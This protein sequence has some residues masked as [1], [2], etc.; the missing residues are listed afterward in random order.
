MLLNRKLTVFALSF[1]LTTLFCVNFPENRF[2]VIVIATICCILLGA[3]SFLK[4]PD[5]FKRIA[6]PSKALFT[7]ALGALVSVVYILIFTGIRLPNVEKLPDDEVYLEGNITEIRYNEIYNTA[8]AKI[9]ITTDDVVKRGTVVSVYFD[10]KSF[11]VSDEMLGEQPKQYDKITFRAFLDADVSLQSLADGV[12]LY[13]QISE[14]A[15]E[16]GQATGIKKV[17]D[18]VSSSIN[19]YLDSVSFWNDNTSGLAKKV[20]TNVSEDINPGLSFSFRRSGIIHFLSISGFH[21]TIIA[22]MIMFLLQLFRIPLR[23]RV[24]ICLVLALLYSAMVGFVPSVVRSLFMLAAALVA[25]LLWQD[26][27]MLTAMSFSLLVI[28]FFNP[29]A[30]SDL[31]LQLSFLSV[32]G[33]TCAISYTEKIMVKLR[34]HKKKN[35]PLI[36]TVKYL[37]KPFAV[38]LFAF[39]FTLPVVLTIFR[40][41]PAISP[42]FNLLAAPLLSILLVL[43]F[44]SAVLGIIWSPLAIPTAFAAGKLSELLFILTSAISGDSPLIIINSRQMLI[45]MVLIVAALVFVLFAKGKKIRLTALVSLGV[46]VL[47]MTGV[48]LFQSLYLSKT[49]KLTAVETNSSSHLVITSGATHLLFDFSSRYIDYKTLSE[50]SITNITACVFDTV[51]ES[52]IFKVKTLVAKNAVKTVYLPQKYI[53]DENTYKLA[54][55]SEQYGFKIQ[56]YGASLLLSFGYSYDGLRFYTAENPKKGFALVAE[57]NDNAVMYVGAMAENPNTYITSQYCSTM[58]LS[59]AFFKNPDFSSLPDTE[60]I[61]NVVAFEGNIYNKGMEKAT[62]ENTENIK[63]AD[64]LAKGKVLITEIT[65][66]GKIKIIK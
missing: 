6:K 12:L 55:I 44:V 58:M 20:V 10:G 2:L 21:M 42:L 11:G 8:F 25:V 63:E 23:V 59:N 27:D 46:A 32:T 43:F 39:L 35:I 66:A 19:T 33:I 24:P 61:Q 5:A 22:G 51:S 3:F 4:L 56:Y 38:S 34:M 7:V 17:L 31:G 29:F 28:L 53:D 26:G 36:W 18:K 9:K 15:L 64:S 50:N 54:A 49:V 45:P 60:D 65:P 52:T 62:A 37:L 47:S 30:I 48:S 41:V 40:E 14:Y 13:A 57:F 1:A 16:R